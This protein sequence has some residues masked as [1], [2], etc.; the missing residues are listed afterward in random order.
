MTPYDRSVHAQVSVNLLP[1]SKLIVSW[2]FGQRRLGSFVLQL[3]S[4]LNGLCMAS[5]ELQDV[6]SFNGDWESPSDTRRSGLSRGAE[7]GAGSSAFCLSIVRWLPSF[8][9]VGGMGKDQGAMGSTRDSRIEDCL[10]I[11]GYLTLFVGLIVSVG[12]EASVSHESSV[13]RSTVAIGLIK[14]SESML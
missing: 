6:V 2:Q 1:A 14:W 3:S 12:G 4:H 11:R 9:R 5:D 10:R 7:A 8:R 13:L